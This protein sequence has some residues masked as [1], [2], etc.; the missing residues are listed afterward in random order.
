MQMLAGDSSPTF[1]KLAFKIR[2]DSL[3]FYFDFSI[4]FTIVLHRISGLIFLK[5]TSEDETLLY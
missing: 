5:V 3:L 1:K 2:S 4:V